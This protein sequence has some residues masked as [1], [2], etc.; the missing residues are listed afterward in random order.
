MTISNVLNCF[1]W[2]NLVDY[3][4]YLRSKNCDHMYQSVFHLSYVFVSLTRV[5]INVCNTC[6]RKEI[7]LLCSFRRLAFSL[8]RDSWYLNLNLNLNGVILA[9][10][11]TRGAL[12]LDLTQP[13]CWGCRK[14]TTDGAAHAAQQVRHRCT[15]PPVL[16][17]SVP[18]PVQWDLISLAIP[19]VVS[20]LPGEIHCT[21]YAS[22]WC[23]L[24]M[25]RRV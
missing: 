10:I 20:F 14:K 6:L 11:C 5:P 2:S 24:S 19:S 13:P 1:L 16:M 21:T 25:L 9:L 8:G 12:K 3:I 22:V 15:L 4:Q 7:R 17:W 23:S 18:Y